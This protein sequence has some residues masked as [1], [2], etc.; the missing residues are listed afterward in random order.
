[1]VDQANIRV[2]DRDRELYWLGHIWD[3]VLLCTTI[4]DRCCMMT[5]SLRC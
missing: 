3:I 2:R 5:L 1:M 4:T